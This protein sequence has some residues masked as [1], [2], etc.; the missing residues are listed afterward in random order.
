VCAVAL[1]VI[2]LMGPAL[3][4]ASS[5]RGT[6]N[7]KS[8]KPPTILFMCP[9]G[10]AKSVLASAYFQRLAKERGLNVHV[11]SAGTEPDA[12]V[13][14]AVAAHLKGQ[15]YPVPNAKPAKVEPEE[16][17][18]ADVVISIGCDLAALPQPR[19]RLVRWDEVPA[20][21]D[22]F[23]AA[24]EAIRKRV[25]VLG[26][27]TRPID[28][29][30]EIVQAP[31]R[32]DRFRRNDVD[33][34]RRRFVGLCLAAPV[35]ASDGTV[36]SAQRSDASRTWPSEFPAL[37]QSV[38]GSPLTYLDSAATTLRPQSV[39]DALVQ[40]YSLDNANPSQV[41]TLASRA[42]D[43]LAAARQTV[44]RFIN[45]ADASEIVFVRGTTQAINLLA[46]AWGPTNLR[47]GDEIVISIAEHASNLMP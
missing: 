24:D 17:A 6:D 35:L 23:T 36:S 46:S 44:A 40:Y 31:E 33:A 3:P 12:T 41:Q 22:D 45:A 11:A 5:Q 27:G 25:N 34:S 10:A 28:A 13:S 39:I 38:H 15:G 7:P 42:A 1:L 2:G 4:V 32:R 47:S 30:D 26:G 8:N 16:F 37:R 29:E 21:S 19:G 20:L 14:P 18:S 9:H 43:H